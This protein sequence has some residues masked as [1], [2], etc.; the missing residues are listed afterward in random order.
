MD[1]QPYIVLR[2]RPR[3]NMQQ[4]LCRMCPISGPLRQ[5]HRRGAANWEAFQARGD[6]YFLADLVIEHRDRPRYLNPEPCYCSEAA[7][8]AWHRFSAA[9]WSSSSF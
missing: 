8:L 4:F 6:P 7:L 3:Q 2:S 1:Y 9:S 5:P